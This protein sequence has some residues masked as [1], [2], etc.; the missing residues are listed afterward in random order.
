MEI[1]NT[2]IH[3]RHVIFKFKGVDSISA[4]E[5]LAGADVAI[6]MEQRAEVPKGEYYQSDLMG[7]ELIDTNGRVLG[8]VTDFQE[9][10]GTPLL[11]VVT[12]E[13]KELLIPF[14]KS[15]CT[16]IDLQQKRIQVN[17]PDGL[18]DLNSA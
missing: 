12:G 10:G 11:E 6:P 17:L 16:S 15:I 3:G 7:C 14:A 4:A 8:R 18:E 9:T 5:R 13:G 1:E 2:W